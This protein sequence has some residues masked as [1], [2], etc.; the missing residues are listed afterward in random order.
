MNQN[1]ITDRIHLKSPRNWINDPNGF[2]YYKGKYHLFYQHFP[3]APM[4]GTMHW[5]HAVSRDMVTW[6]HT[7]IALFPT[8]Y[9]DQ[10]GC[11]SGS[12]V[13]HDGRMHL[14]YTGVHYHKADPSNIH[15]CF[16]DMFEASQLTIS[17]EDGMHF[18]N[19]H[20]KRIAV[21]PITDWNKGDL[22]HTRDPK[23]WR[24]KDAWYMMLGSSMDWKGRRTGRLLFYESR[25]LSEWK[26]LNCAAKPGIFGWMWECPDYFETP[27][28]SVLMFCSL[29]IL[30]DGFQEEDQIVCMMADFDEETCRMDIPDEYQYADYGMQLY[31]AQST[32]DEQGRRVMTAWMRMPEPVDGRW[33]GMFCMPRIV[34]VKNGHIYFRPHPNISG[35]F[36]R[37]IQSPRE[38][39][40]GKASGAEHSGRDTPG[41]RYR[42]HAKL[43]EGDSINAGGCLIYYKNGRIHADK[44]AVTCRKKGQRLHVQTPDIKGM[45]EADIYVDAH[46]VEIFVNDGEYVIS[47][48]VSGMS[49]EL[50]ADRPEKVTV[51]AERSQ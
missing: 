26:F 5:G 29:G 34:E 44:S 33:I 6:E 51:Y 30:K 3:Y 19:F 43:E 40:G 4:W 17:S 36:T 47:F 2:I 12:A 25:D 1:K 16:N 15:V 32:L 24:G 28:G 42:I 10:N 39:F 50:A 38:A 35:L 14:F 21:P 8:R 23:V 13:E 7:G 41:G 22:I 31:A 46:I 27:G 37:E 18:D 48:S 45:C 20:G 49:H 9:E 11:F